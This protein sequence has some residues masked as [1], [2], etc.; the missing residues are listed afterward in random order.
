MRRA[1]LAIHCAEARCVGG[2]GRRR[3]GHV[4]ASPLH[5]AEKEDDRVF[6]YYARRGKYVLCVVCRHLNGD[7]FI[8]TAYLTDRI[9]KGVTVYEADSDHL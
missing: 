4:A 8:I 9:K 5:S 6:L 1:A 7:G 3:G 2:P